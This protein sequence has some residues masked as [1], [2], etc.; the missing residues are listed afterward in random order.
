MPNK[1][2]AE[3][4]DLPDNVFKAAMGNSDYFIWIRPGSKDTTSLG[5]DRAL[6]VTAGHALNN[7][8][9]ET[10]VPNFA[11]NDEAKMPR[12]GLVLIQKYCTDTGLSNGQVRGKIGRGVWIRGVHYYVI[13]R[14]TWI[15]VEAVE[16]WIKSAASE[17][18]EP[19]SNPGLTTSQR[20][21]RRTSKKA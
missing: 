15:D 1:S 12:T 6:A 5:Q 18:G 10:E 11:A 4:E 20:G 9:V 21:S 7:T 3:N 19:K 2:A 16:A 14:A 13:E 8:L 17:G